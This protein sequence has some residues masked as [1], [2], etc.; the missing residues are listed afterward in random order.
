MYPKK[1]K[2]KKNISTFFSNYSV[3]KQ[4]INWMLWIIKFKGCPISNSSQ[5][6]RLLSLELGRRN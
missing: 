1:T 5:V 2:T 6:V 4:I 3:F